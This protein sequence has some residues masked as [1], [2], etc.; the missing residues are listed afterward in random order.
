MQE[1]APNVYIETNYIGVNVGAIVTTEGVVCVD[2][3]TCPADAQDWLSTIHQTFGLPIR[4]LILTDY[5]NDRVVSAHTFRTRIVA[6]EKTQAILKSYDT[7]YPTAL[8]DTVA[9][10]Y[11]LTRKE[12]NGTPVAYPQV[13]FCDQATIKLGEQDI[14]LLSMPSAT[15][16]SIWVN[17]AEQEVL[18]AGDTL[19]VDQHPPLAEADPHGWLAALKQLKKG[20]IAKVIVPGRGPLGTASTIK[21]VEKYIKKSLDKVCELFNAGRPRADTTV[22]IPEFLKLFP[23][24]F[25]STEENTDWLQK[26]LKIG[27]DHIYDECKASVSNQQAA[28]ESA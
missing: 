1:I 23:H 9:S 20:K 3:P 4:Y 17:L 12:L 15:P 24:P 11:D 6:H 26:Q 5:Q 25:P 16:G 27:L 28:K 8:L 7:R 14:Q 22:L 13:S 18:F 10:R 21:E 2:S 19:V